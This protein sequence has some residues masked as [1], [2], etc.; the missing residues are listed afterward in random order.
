MFYLKLIGRIVNVTAHVL[1]NTED[2]L[3]IKKGID[4][5]FISKETV[6]YGREIFTASGLLTDKSFGYHLELM[7]IEDYQPGETVLKLIHMEDAN[8]FFLYPKPYNFKNNEYLVYTIGEY[9]GAVY[10]A[11]E[12]LEFDDFNI[13][14]LY[15][16][17]LQLDD[18]IGYGDL[19][20]SI[21]Y[22][23]IE[24]ALKIT[25]VDDN[26][27]A[28]Q[29]IVNMLKNGKAEKIDYYRLKIDAGEK[30]SHWYHIVRN[31]DGELFNNW[32]D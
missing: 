4:N 20:S 11:I 12:G 15:I 13:E 31:K 27:I 25:K 19:I 6:S 5:G 7:E 32:T 3:A 26:K 22:V 23:P 29:Y 1:N 10:C 8:T 2:I 9:S 18:E 24:E 16:G 14:D 28:R 17:E 30:F 21:Y